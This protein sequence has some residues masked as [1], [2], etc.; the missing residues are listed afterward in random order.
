VTHGESTTGILQ[1]V[2]RRESLHTFGILGPFFGSHVQALEICCGG[3][4]KVNFTTPGPWLV[5]LISIIFIHILAFYSNDRMH[6]HRDSSSKSQERNQALASNNQ[7]EI[8]YC[9][10]KLQHLLWSLICYPICTPVFHWYCMCFCCRKV[11][12]Q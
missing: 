8:Q 10:G 1:T 11:V 7:R 3:W 5:C 2:E 12:D 4:F 9:S 6:F